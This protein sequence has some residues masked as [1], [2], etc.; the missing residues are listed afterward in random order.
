MIDAASKNKKW[1]VAMMLDVPGID[2]NS[3]IG[4]IVK[5]R[6]PSTN[7]DRDY[8]LM[9]AT[10]IG[11]NKTNQNKQCN[12]IVEFQSLPADFSSFIVGR[13]I[14]K[15]GNIYVVNRIDPLFF[16]LSTQSVD[17]G[18]Q[19]S[20]EPFDQ[21]LEKSKLPRQVCEAIPEIQMKHICKT[22]DNDDICYLK[23][24]VEKTLKWLQKKQERLFESLIIQ[25]QRN[26]KAKGVKY[27]SFNNNITGVMGGSMSANFNLPPQASRLVA[28]TSCNEDKNSSNAVGLS[29]NTK[30]IK[31]ESIQIICNYLNQDW[32]KKFIEHLGCTMEVISTTTKTTNKAAAGDSNYVSNAVIQQ[33]IDDDISSKKIAEA[34]KKAIAETRTM[35]N[36][37]LAKVSTKG[38]KSMSSFFGAAVKTKKAKH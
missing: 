23:F 16:Y 30:S 11:G 35:G 17:D 12:N 34:K 5:I 9:A 1:I 29:N 19:Q 36:K 15:D 4:N 21:N 14:V 10:T 25:D 7:E 37:R 28:A 32:S 26:R 20:W 38:M 2:C 31:T 33:N 24:N 27:A 13:H 3:S 18:Q 8:G 6:D 22:F